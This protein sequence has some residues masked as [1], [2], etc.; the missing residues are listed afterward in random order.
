MMKKRAMMCVFEISLD[1]YD[2]DIL[3]EWAF[4][5]GVGWLYAGVVERELATWREVEK[6]EVKGSS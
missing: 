4:M 1:L 3:M 2:M 6:W 5:S